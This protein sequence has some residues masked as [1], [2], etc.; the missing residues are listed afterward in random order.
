MKIFPNKL[1]IGDEIRVIAPSCSLKLI[2]NSNINHA[3]QALENLGLRV[4]FGKNVEEND[5]FNSSSIKSRIE[6]LHEAFVDK[7]VKAVLTVIGGHNSN[8]LL[9]H[10]DYDLIKNN[11]KIFCGY[12]DITAMQNAIFHK[13]GLVTYSGM[14]F[15]SFAIQKGYEYSVEHFKKIFFHKSEFDIIPSEYWS[16]DE[17][18]LDQ[19]NRIFN[20]N[21]GYKTINTGEAEGTIIGGNLSTLQLLL[22]TEFMPS[23]KDCI[24]FIESDAAYGDSCVEEFDR[25]LQSLVHQPDFKTVKALVFGRFEKKFCMSLE[26]L[27]MIINTKEELKKIPIIAEADFGHTTPMFTFPI[28]GICKLIA[29]LSSTIIKILEH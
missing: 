20:Q 19:E 29:N 12:S 28:G 23:I 10:I 4:S 2:S 1:S 26:K 3:I 6:D 8:Q 25:D 9:N 24:L 7:N 5:I 13:T 14:H 15:S 18:Y 21:D 27:K 11:P 22:G 17:W 16:D